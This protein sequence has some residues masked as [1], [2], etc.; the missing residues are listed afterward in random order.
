MPSLHR[1]GV[2]PKVESSS[3]T[4]PSAPLSYPPCQPP[5]TLPI[6]CTTASMSPP[7]GD[8]SNPFTCSSPTPPSI[9]PSNPF[10]TRLQQNP[11]FEDLIA[12]EALTSPVYSPNSHPARMSA[13]KRER[14]R[15]MARQR[16]LPTIMSETPDT[17]NGNPNYT[18][19]ERAGE[20]DDFEAFATSRL[21]SPTGT[22]TRP[23]S[24]SRVPD[25]N[26]MVYVN[27]ADNRLR[28]DEV[29][30]DVP[31]PWDLPPLPPRR[32]VRN[33]SAG[34]E[35]F[36][37]SWLDRA[38]ELAVQKEACFLSQTDFASLQHVR[39]GDIKRNSEIL[40][41][42]IE[43]YTDR[44]SSVER[45]KME[46]E[47]QTDLLEF[48]EERIVPDG[49]HPPNVV[50]ASDLTPNNIPHSSPNGFGEDALHSHHS[51]PETL[52][53]PSDFD[54]TV[55]ES[56]CSSPRTQPK[57]DSESSCEINPKQ[58][59]QKQTSRTT[60]DICLL[61]LPRRD[62][63]NNTDSTSE[64][65]FI[66]SGSSASEP[67]FEMIKDVKASKVSSEYCILNSSGNEMSPARCSPGL[68]EDLLCK[69]TSQLSP[70]TD[71]LNHNH[72]DSSLFQRSR[73]E[74]E[75]KSRQCAASNANCEVDVLR[76]KDISVT[77]QTRANDD[78]VTRM[79]EHVAAENNNVT[80][81]THDDMLVQTCPTAE[82]E[83]VTSKASEIEDFSLT[84]DERISFEDL[85]A[86]VAPKG[87][88]SPYVKSARIRPR[89]TTNSPKTVTDAESLNPASE[90]LLHVTSPSPFPLACTSACLHP[91]PPLPVNPPNEMPSMGSTSS[92]KAQ[93]DASLALSPE[94][95]QPA[96]VLLPLEESR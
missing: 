50:L 54:T 85:H 89:S 75:V 60:N 49:G 30:M 20:Y 44:I 22:P 7:S 24:A 73:E 35:R 42:N 93:V 31:K 41:L 14:P 68:P 86:K 13:I 25:V 51:E 26:Q 2:S 27:R 65:A 55:T 17:S 61:V 16:S 19:S 45:D 87:S 72:L 63:N 48:K 79:K 94:E 37:D 92:T 3:D 96:S 90:P 34:R 12:E 32:P 62:S 43:S 40:G 21:K 58:N 23:P 64:F 57:H 29:D 70:K 88:R 53:F 15:S 69:M 46:T 74:Q 82:S 78:I 39:E 9:S 11:F 76:N 83:D 91:D 1:L 6:R 38:Q 8:H 81:A 36:S 4:N 77:A 28:V 47:M 59:E 10:L 80:H 18:Q 5:C 56:L 33:Q 71:T 84:Q 52:C 67:P 95:T 66:D